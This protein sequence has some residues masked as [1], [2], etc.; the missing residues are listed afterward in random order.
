MR[1]PLACSLQVDAKVSVIDPTTGKGNDIKKAASR[2][3]FI[4]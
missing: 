2:R 1:T 3:F 4:I